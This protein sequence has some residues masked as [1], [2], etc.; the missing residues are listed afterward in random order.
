MTFPIH[1]YDPINLPNL[2]PPP[3]VVKIQRPV[4]IFE[5]SGIGLKLERRNAQLKDRR[6][7]MGPWHVMIVL[8]V[9]VR[10]ICIDSTNSVP[11]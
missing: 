10:M 4:K 8:L 1:T 6:T 11:V 7:T 5:G 9:G 3:A 2:T